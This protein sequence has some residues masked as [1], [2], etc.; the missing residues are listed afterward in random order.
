MNY[1]NPLFHL[2]D[3]N[4]QQVRHIEEL[5]SILSENYYDT[6]YERKYDARLESI[7]ATVQLSNIPLSKSEIQTLYVEGALDFEDNYTEEALGVINAYKNAVY[8]YGKHNAYMLWLHDCMMNGISEYA[9]RYRRESFTCPLYDSINY[10]C[11][12][13]TEVPYRTAELFEY[14]LN[15]CANPII[16]SLVF[17]IELLRI[18]PFVDANDRIARL[19]SSM[20]LDDYNDIFELIPLEVEILNNQATYRNAIK[21]SL[22]EGNDDAFISRM[23][24]ILETGLTRTLNELKNS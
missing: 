22:I 4:I 13:Y 21:T 6:L 2:T 16:A 17:H 23:L 8:G 5:V 12:D 14:I 10:T 7:H 9:G 24:L 15:T 11:S 1:D 20:I 3:E 18:S 19:V